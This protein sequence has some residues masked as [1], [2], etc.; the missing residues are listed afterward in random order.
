MQEFNSI[1]LDSQPQPLVYTTLQSYL[2]RT[3]PFLDF[4][5]AHA[6][7]HDYALGIKLVRGAYV[8]TELAAHSRTLNGSIIPLSP[9]DKPPTFSSKQETDAAYDRCVSV[10]V[11][12]VASESVPKVGVMFGTHNW[13]SCKLVLDEIVRVGLGKEVDLPISRG[14]K[15]VVSEQVAKRVC[16]AQL[17]GELL[18]L[19]F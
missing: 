3:P 14:K 10:L 18:C 13:K 17:Y 11:G 7:N 12:Q 16:M 19:I 9:E 15:I 2:V 8:D 5:I 4:L 6:K 1:K